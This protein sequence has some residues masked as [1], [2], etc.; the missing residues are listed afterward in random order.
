[1]SYLE[2]KEARIILLVFF[3]STFKSSY[4]R[5]EIKISDT[6]PYQK[7]HNQFVSK[8]TYLFNM[9]TSQKLIQFDILGVVRYLFI[10]HLFYI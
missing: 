4:Q 9:S 5:R 6:P 8:I 7:V 3:G 1:M 2:S 10:D